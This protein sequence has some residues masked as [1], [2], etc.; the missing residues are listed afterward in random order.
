MKKITGLLVLCFSVAFIYNSCKKEEK[1]VSPPDPENEF[2]TT[3]QLIIT[4]A[5]DPT[6]KQTVAVKQMPDEEIDYSDAT[7]NL[8][9]NTVYNVSVK[10]LDETTDPAGD[11]T[12]DI[13][14]RRN[15]HLICFNVSGGAKLTIER[16][17]K[18]T[19]K[20][21]LEIGLEDTFTTGDAGSGSL[22]V[23]LRHQPNAKNGS[24]EPG[25]SDADVDFTV[26]I[27]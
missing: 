4:N 19:N 3:V 20:P 2:L 23:Q 26:N 5:S 11:I 15:Y 12:E 14:D 6:D 10:F 25:S 1:T 16:T 21:A 22:N 18:D 7:M 24:C 8:K 17:D 27:N 13:Y 9:K